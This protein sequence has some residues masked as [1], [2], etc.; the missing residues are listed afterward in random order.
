MAS[1]S[2]CL[3]Q[4]CSRRL[5]S[6]GHL[7]KEKE[8]TRLPQNYRGLYTLIRIPPNDLSW[9]LHTS[10]HSFV[11]YFISLH[12]PLVFAAVLSSG[13]DPGTRGPCSGPCVLEKPPTPSS[14]CAPPQRARPPIW[15]QE[16]APTWGAPCRPLL[17]ND[18]STRDSRIS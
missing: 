4:R 18:L 2:L 17:D 10:S 16:P 3:P 9:P 5:T 6:L 8:G 1:L 7:P 13:T 12:S 14:G 15:H 11:F